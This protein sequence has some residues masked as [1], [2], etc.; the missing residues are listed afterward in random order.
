MKNRITIL[1]ENAKPMPTGIERALL[2]KEVE[3]AWQILLNMLAVDPDDKVTV[4]KVEV[5]E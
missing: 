5:F 1:A 4:E 3:K 2:E